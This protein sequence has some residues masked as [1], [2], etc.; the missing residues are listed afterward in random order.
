MAAIANF[1]GLGIVTLSPHRIAVIVSAATDAGH[2]A[3]TRNVAPASGAIPMRVA[4]PNAT[5][6][7][8]RCGRRT[9]RAGSS[10]SRKDDSS[11]VEQTFRFYETDSLLNLP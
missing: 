10:P 6:N 4:L 3:N 8:P 5:A 2:P 1:E 11:V 7:S 9:S